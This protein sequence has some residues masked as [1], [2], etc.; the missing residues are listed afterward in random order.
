MSEELTTVFKMTPVDKPTFK[1][2]Y[3][4]KGYVVTYTTEELDGN[5]LIIDAITYAEAR[6][7]VCVIDGQ[8]MKKSDYTVINKLI[9][10]DEG[11]ACYFD[12]ISILTNEFKTKIWSPRTREYRTNN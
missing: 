11:Q 8:I 7:D 6:P 3:D 12:D 10:S 4:E 5:Y 9:P 2:Y 1:L